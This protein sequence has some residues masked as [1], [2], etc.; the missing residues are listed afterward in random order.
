M[1]TVHTVEHEGRLR[2]YYH[3]TATGIRRLDEFRDDWDEILAI[4]RFIT[5]EDETNDEN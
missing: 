5:K 2:K 3:I 1:L 4:Y